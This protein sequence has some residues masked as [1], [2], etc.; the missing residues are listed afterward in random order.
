MFQHNPDVIMVSGPSGCGKTT[1]TEKAAM[2]LRG[3]PTRWFD[4]LVGSIVYRLGVR[5]NI[6]A[7]AW[8]MFDADWCHTRRAKRNAARGIPMNDEYR[9]GWVQRVQVE[10]RKLLAAGYRVLLAC[11]AIQEWVR[12][13][14]LTI[15]DTTVIAWLDVPQAVLES[16]IG[17]RKG[18]W[19][20]ASLL[21]SQLAAVEHC[22]EGD[23]V[24]R[25]QCGSLPAVQIA[26]MIVRMIVEPSLLEHEAVAA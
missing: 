23:R 17:A 19:F 4:R 18:H 22:E 12:S 25:I 5:K 13:E 7:G 16:R 11:S 2:L 6:A 15:S 21:A 8:V 1:V 3:R 10:V 20:P 24:V 26:R 9:K 14:L